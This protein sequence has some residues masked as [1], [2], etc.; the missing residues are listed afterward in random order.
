M[1]FQINP[2]H[3]TKLDLSKIST[4]KTF[5]DIDLIL[6]LHKK[7]Y[8]EHDFVIIESC[9]LKYLSP[10]LINNTS[11]QNNSGQLDIKFDSNPI[12]PVYIINIF[13]HNQK[14]NFQFSAD[15]NQ[16][17]V[18][19]NIV[20][21]EGQNHISIRNSGNLNF[22]SMTTSHIEGIFHENLFIENASN[23]SA[24]FMQNEHQYLHK[25]DVKIILEYN[26]KSN[27]NILNSLKNKQ[28]K[29]D[30]F[31]IIQR[32]TNSKSSISYLSLNNG[33][34]VSQIN[35]IV[36]K[37]A[38]DCD[39]EQHI[40]HILVSEKAQSYSKPSLMIHAPTVASHGNTIS[41]FPE[42]WLFYLYQKGI[43]PHNSQKIIEHSMINEFCVQTPFESQFNAYFRKEN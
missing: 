9:L 7:Q 4:V 35:N 6:A 31:E 37:Y 11:I 19:E 28:I 8:P 33:K 5:F 40:K 42:E 32:G 29:D 1:N 17:V 25:L 2:F 10:E 27:I 38:L 16:S 43:N 3:Y 23:F 13:S 30:C 18:Y 12:K 15:F 22:Y 20:G 36:E 24:F 14:L 41:S 26:A 39:L 34:A 21:E